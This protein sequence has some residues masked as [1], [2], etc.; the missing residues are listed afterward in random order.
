MGTSRTQQQ[1]G[2]SEAPAAHGGHSKELRGQRASGAA[3]ERASFSRHRESCGAGR[4]PCRRA[5][6]K[7]RAQQARTSGTEQWGKAK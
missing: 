6:S 1:A 7:P 3:G 2:A 4:G 5:G